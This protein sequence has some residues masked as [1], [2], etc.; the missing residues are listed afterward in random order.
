MLRMSLL[1]LMLTATPAMA[2]APGSSFKF[3]YQTYAAG[4]NV[5]DINGSFSADPQN[6]QLELNYHTSGFLGALFRFQLDSRVNGTWTRDSVDPLQFYSW[7]DVRGRPRRTLIEYQDGMPVV[8][9]LQPPHDQD[10]QPIPPDMERNT[11]DSLSAMALLMHEVATTGRCDGSVDTFD[12]RRVSRIT[13]HTVGEESIAPSHD[14]PYAGT[15]LRCD[16]TGQQLA[17][18]VLDQDQAR[19]R[20]PHHGSAWFATVAPGGMP[21]PVRITF[22]ADWFGQATAYLTSI[23]PEAQATEQRSAGN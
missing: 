2:Q 17:G 7:G 4:F 13:S 11:V 6:Y 10:R 15:T 12:G 19:L 22:D 9:D 5:L 1:S 20:K 21:V 16:F 3:S 23:T 18:F 14:S 8:R